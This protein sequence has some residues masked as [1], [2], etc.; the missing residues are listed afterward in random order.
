[1]SCTRN[2]N[3][4]GNYNLEQE[5]YLQSHLYNTNIIHKESNNTQYAG[6]GLLSSYIPRTMLSYNPIEI[7]STLFGIGS[8]NLVNPKPKITPR[9]KKLNTFNLY[10]NEK[11]IIPKPLVIEKNMRPNIYNN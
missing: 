7:E 1:M 8:T 9:L 2:K 10:E 6:N 4:L 5:Q 3:T 11:V